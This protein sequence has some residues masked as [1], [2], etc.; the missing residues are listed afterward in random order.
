MMQQSG[1]APT[2]QQFRERFVAYFVRCLGPE[3]A[4]CAEEIW[5]SYWDDPDQRADGPEECAAAELDE[6]HD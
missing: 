6:W 2:R 5:E 1:E 4:G 3:L